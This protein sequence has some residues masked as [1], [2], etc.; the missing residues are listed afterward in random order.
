MGLYS[1]YVFP[2]LMDWL[3]RGKEFQRL[4]DDL[5]TV[6]RGDVL[7]IGFGS[8]L[9]LAHYPPTVHHLTAVDPARF[10]PDIVARRTA[11]VAFPVEIH[12]H[13][14]ETL[15]FADQRFDWVVSTWTLCSIADPV[16]ALTE[17]RRVLKPDGRFV[18]LEHG[19]CQ[20]ERVAAWQDRLNPIQNVLGCGCHLNRRIDRLVEHGGLR[21]MQLDRFPMA[22]VP[23]LVG[24]MYRGWAEPI[25]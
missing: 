18:F 4:R 7:E 1:S 13:A 23:Q 9:N 16:Q 3:M 25:P 14:A 22:D 21:L 20:D 8:G 19:R 5:L 24:A 10:L 11:A 12:H 17:V 15:S 6:V 2:H